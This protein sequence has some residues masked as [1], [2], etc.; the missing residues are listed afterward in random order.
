MPVKYSRRPQGG[1]V[2][3]SERGISVESVQLLGESL[4]GPGLW[5]P[6]RG[7]GA[8]ETGPGL[9]RP[10]RGPGA[11]ETGP[12]ARGSGDRRAGAGVPRAWNQ[13]LPQSLEAERNP[14]HTEGSPGSPDHRGL[15]GFS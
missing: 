1:A 3:L 4:W 14:L 10:A 13:G 12:G 6:A 7:P 11:L 5:R 15:T 2:D 8:L 9:W